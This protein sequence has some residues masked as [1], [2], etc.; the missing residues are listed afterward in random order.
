MPPISTAI[1]WKLSNPSLSISAHKWAQSNLDFSDYIVVFWVFDVDN[2]K[3]E[4]LHF[5]KVVI[6]RKATEVW[7][8]IV[9]G[10]FSL[11]DLLPF[12]VTALVDS[13]LSIG[14]ILRV[15]VKP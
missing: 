14:L 15:Q 6:H 9:Y 8:E 11:T 12:V 2:Y 7:I 13:A 3:S 5:F 4:L 1:V 10:N